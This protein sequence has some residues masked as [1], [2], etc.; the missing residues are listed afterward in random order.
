MKRVFV[1]AFFITVVLC[2]QVYPSK[3]SVV[4][5]CPSFNVYVSQHFKGEKLIIDG[6]IE[7]LYYVPLI[8]IIGYV[9]GISHNRIIEK[10]EFYIG[11]IGEWQDVDSAKSFEI[12]FQKGDKIKKL[13]FTINYNYASWKESVNNYE[14][15]T[16]K[17]LNR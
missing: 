16:L 4:Y 8:D 13:K 10:K 2:S 3:M 9:D 7:N 14:Y 5:N 12:V 15:F 17:V 11:Y 1:L 6:K